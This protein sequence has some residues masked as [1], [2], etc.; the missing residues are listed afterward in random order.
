MPLSNLGRVK[1]GGGEGKQ[2]K[3]KVYAAEHIY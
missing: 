3:F 1:G 2:A